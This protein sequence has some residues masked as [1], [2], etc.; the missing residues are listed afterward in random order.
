MTNGGPVPGHELQG[1]AVNKFELEYSVIS[2]FNLLEA[3]PP[4]RSCPECGIRLVANSVP[5][6]IGMKLERFK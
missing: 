5:G 6:A 3:T 2:T 1:M 4:Q